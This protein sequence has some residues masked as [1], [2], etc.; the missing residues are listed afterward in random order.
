VS[1]RGQSPRRTG[2]LF[3]GAHGPELAH[4]YLWR[5][6]SQVPG[7]GEIVIFNRSHYEDVLVVRVHNLV[8]P[9]VCKRRYDQINA[10]EQLL[11]EE[12]TTILKFF[13]HI[14]AEEQR[15]GC[16]PAWMNLPSAGSS[17]LAI[18]KNASCG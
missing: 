16:S 9:E 15:S 12:G 2:G 6:H 3:Q 8:P 18:W 11:V 14:D 13:L 1:S 4:D 5:V 17:T 10:F 7:R